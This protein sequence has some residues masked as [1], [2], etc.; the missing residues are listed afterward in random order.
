LPHADRI[1]RTFATIQQ[2]EAL[3]VHRRAGLWP[4]RAAEYGDDVRGRLQGAEAVE[5]A[6]YLDALEERRRI[7]R[8]FAA[9]FAEVDVILTPV[10]AAGPVPIGETTAWAADGARVPL[11]DL[12]MPYTVPQ[13]LVGLP[14]CAVRAGF[15]DAGLPIAVQLT[16]ALGADDLVLDVATA[17][18]AATTDVQNRWPTTQEDL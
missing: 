2:A 4:A 8:R 14:A 7:A 5:L 6:D 9:A 13:D 15:D 10:A 1:L 11:R 18:H 12:V 3:H 16:G 17:L